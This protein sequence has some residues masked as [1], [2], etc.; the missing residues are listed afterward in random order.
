MGKSCPGCGNGILESEEECDNYNQEGCVNCK[1][2]PKKVDDKNINEKNWPECGN[3]KLE[4][5]EECDEASDSC[6]LCKKV[7][8]KS[9]P[10]C[11]NKKIEDGEECDDSS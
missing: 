6:I 11:G 10:L 8:S 1:L 5:G 7:E 9:I 4:D 3:G 2:V